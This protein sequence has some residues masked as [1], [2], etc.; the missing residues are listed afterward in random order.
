MSGPQVIVVGAGLSGLSAAHTLYEKGANVL[1]L[2]KVRDSS[3]PSFAVG[4]SPSRRSRTQLTLNRSSAEPV[5]RRYVPPLLSGKRR[6]DA[7]PPPF[8]ATAGNSTSASFTPT[9]LLPALRD[10][11]IETVPTRR[12]HVGHQRRRHQGALRPTLRPFLVLVLTL[13]LSH[14]RRPRRSSAS[15]TRRPPSSPTPRSRCVAPFSR[16]SSSLAR[17]SLLTLRS[18]CRNRLASSRATTSSRCSPVRLLIAVVS[19][20]GTTAD[21]RGPAGHSGDAVEW[22]INNFGCVPLS[23]LSLSA[24]SP[25]CSRERV[26][27][28]RRGAA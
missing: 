27:G 1:V 24:L 13:S 16:S 11:T 26:G 14:V 9:L 8:P 17:S 10:L 2:E 20:R 19:W 23:L 12:G 7:D 18:A 22:L 4:P 15:R 3:P 21:E 5:R 25:P 6:A 28:E